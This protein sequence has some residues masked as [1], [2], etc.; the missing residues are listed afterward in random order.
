MSRKWEY[1]ST[2]NKDR[3]TEICDMIVAEIKGRGGRF[4]AKHPTRENSYTELRGAKTRMKVAQAL[5]EKK[6]L[7][8]TES[9]ARR[10]TPSPSRRHRQIIP[11]VLNASMP[12]PNADRKL[13]ADEDR[14]DVLG[15][16]F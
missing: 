14:Q 11:P 1:Q 9:V 13:S 5:R 15:F 16:K 3:K 2:P 12:P 4:L 6:E 8:M 10:R 7:K